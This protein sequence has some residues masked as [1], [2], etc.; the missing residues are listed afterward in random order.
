MPTIH[1]ASLRRRVL[2]F[3]ID[4]AIISVYLVLLTIVFLL[5]PAPLVARLFATPTVAQLTG[6]AVLTGPVVLYFVL[7]EAGPRQATLGKRAL[8]LYVTDP[9][10]RRLA[11]LRSLARSAIKFAPWELAHACLWRIEGW[12]TNPEPPDGLPLIGLILVWLLVAAYVL[13][14]ILRAD[15]RALYDLATGSHVATAPAPADRL[16]TTRQ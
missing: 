1:H 10:G 3:A 16:P 6:I 4:Y 9:G 13:P 12:P 7:S 5:L 8:V 2:A 11:R 15:S 14:A